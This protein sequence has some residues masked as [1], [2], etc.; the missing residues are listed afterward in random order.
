VRVFLDTNVLVSA[1][2]TRGMCADVLRVVLAEHTLITS[3]VVLR[4]LS[5]VL[6]TRIGMPSRLVEEVEAFLREHEVA[7]KPAAP[8]A[9]PIRDKDDRWVFASAVEGRADV[10]VT[11]DRDLLDVAGAAPLKIVDPRGFWQLSRKS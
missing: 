11:G 4:E 5:R 8:S 7:G 6:R 2:A 1:F 10:F 3:E 9:L